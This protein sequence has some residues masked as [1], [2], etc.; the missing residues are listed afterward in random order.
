M[1]SNDEE[2]IAIIER[3]KRDIDCT[4]QESAE[5]KV[6]LRHTIILPQSNDALILKD[7]QIYFPIEYGEYLDEQTNI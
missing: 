1:E 7:I 2:L 3:K 4:E 6:W 5:I